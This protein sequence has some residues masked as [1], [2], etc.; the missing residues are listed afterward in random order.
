M[1]QLGPIIISPPDLPWG[2]MVNLK[3]VGHFSDGKAQAVAIAPPTK[4]R[5]SDG[6]QPHITIST[7]V[8]VGPFASN[9]LF[10]GEWE[11]VRGLPAVKAQIGWVDEAERV[12]LGPPPV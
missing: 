4:L 1:I 10:G 12:H 5:R 6:R 3:V 9:F 7:A 8:D 2:R 11:P